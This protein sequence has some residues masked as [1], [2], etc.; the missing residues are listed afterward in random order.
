M[1]SL[2]VYV[3]VCVQCTR[4]YIHMHPRRLIVR[5]T[6]SPSHYLSPF[7]GLLPSFYTLQTPLPP[8]GAHTHT[9]T[10]SSAR[11]AASRPP[12]VSYIFLCVCVCI[13]FSFLGCFSSF[14]SFPPPLPSRL[15]R[16][17]RL[18]V[19]GKQFAF[20][21]VVVVVSRSGLSRR[22][23]RNCESIAV[24]HSLHL[25]LCVCVRARVCVCLGVRARLSLKSRHILLS[26]F[27]LTGTPHTFFID[28]FVSLVAGAHPTT[29]PPS[30]SGLCSCSVWCRCSCSPKSSSLWRR[31]GLLNMK[32]AGQGVSEGR[33]AGR[34]SRR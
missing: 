26:P 25:S 16:G 6:A 22:S 18:E 11:A 24:S 17:Y 20:S 2:C 34:R 15:C 12:S 5:T 1:V 7:P 28:P 13:P 8:T 33:L 3:C 29:R 30:L 21:V 23:C 9:H 14:S 19:W 27:V 10:Q 32:E 31:M 4:L